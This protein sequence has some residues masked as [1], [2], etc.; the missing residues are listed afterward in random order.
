MT[1]QE[2]GE[3]LI[4]IGTAMRLGG[5]DNPAPGSA[6]YITLEAM[7]NEAR[8][9]AGNNYDP[10]AAFINSTELQHYEDGTGAIQLT[11]HFNLR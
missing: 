2:L 1:Q 5:C 10:A 8:N 11:I 6:G 4:R 3:H 9:N 7:A